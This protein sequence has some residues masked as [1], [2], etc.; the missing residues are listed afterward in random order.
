MAR[1]AL[2]LVVGRVSGIGTSSL[3]NRLA[4]PRAWLSFLSTCRNEYAVAV[5]RLVR[6]ILIGQFSDD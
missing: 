6:A 3:R 5:R 1:T 2:L 4:M